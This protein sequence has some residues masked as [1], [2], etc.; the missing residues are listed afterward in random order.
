M[1]L[2]I[3]NLV[4]GLSFSLAG[5]I[6]PELSSVYSLSSSQAA[7]VPYYHFIGNFGGLLLLGILIQKAR[8]ITVA[9]TVL[10]FGSSLYLALIPG[11]T[12]LFKLSFLVLGAS[13]TVLVALPG[14]I[15]SRADPGQAAKNLSFLFAFFCIGV[16]LSPAFTSALIRF[17]FSYRGAFLIL[18][19]AAGA[20][21]TTSIVFRRPLPDLG[22]G[23]SPAVV[24]GAFKTHGLFLVIIIVI[25]F[26]YG[27]AESIPNVWIPKYLQDRG[28]SAGMDVRIILSLFWAAMTVGRYICSWLVAR[29]VKPLILLLSLSLLGGAVLFFTP[30]L[31]H[32]GYSALGFILTGLFLS[33]MYPLIIAWVD[34]LPAKYTSMFMIVWAGSMAGGSVMSR[35]A[36]RV[37]ES[38]SFNMGISI[39]A[40]PLALIALLL[41]YARNQTRFKT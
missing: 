15:L 4:S 32:P 16:I 20:A 37:I 3:F 1:D 2:I 18:S 27:A 41:F 11:F 26:L 36:G 13:S 8:T 7:L 23:L 29:F 28:G 19:L 33:G 40:V 10:L 31:V 14:M 38:V 30:R 34:Y 39:G 21:L 6:L 22:E 35:V 12:L 9:S 5:S 25:A 24:G 17:G